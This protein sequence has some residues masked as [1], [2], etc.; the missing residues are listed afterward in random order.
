MNPRKLM[1]LTLAGAVVGTAFGVAARK[2]FL[3]TPATPA[4]ALVQP[5]AVK[6]TAPAPAAP[7]VPSALVVPSASSP[8][9][10]LVGYV[11]RGERINAQLS[12]GRILTESDGLKILHRNKLVLQDG[13]VFWLLTPGHALPSTP[14]LPLAAVSVK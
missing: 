5:P 1:L 3:A 7:V 10:T 2:L 12:D 6:E 8:P 14:A 4:P 13:T 9:V 11:V